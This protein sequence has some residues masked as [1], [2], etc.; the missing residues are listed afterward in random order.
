MKCSNCSEDI[1]EGARFCGN[2]GEPA[3]AV[4]DTAAAGP[5]TQASAAGVASEPES[6]GQE[7]F[8]TAVTSSKHKNISKI[9]MAFLI[10]LVTLLVSSIA[11]AAY[12]LF[13]VY[14]LPTNQEQEQP[15]VSESEETTTFELPTADSTTQFQ[16]P[17]SN[18]ASGSSSEY[19]VATGYYEFDI[20]EYWRGKVGWREET[21]GDIVVYPLQFPTL[22]L[23]TVR[24]EDASSPENAG[25]VATHESASFEDES[26]HR[27][28]IWTKNWVW[29]AAEG[30][31]SS[32]LYNGVPASEI[33][34]ADDVMCDLSTGGTVT[35][36]QAKALSPGSSNSAFL[37]D[38]QFIKTDVMSSF[39]ILP[40]HN[41][42]AVT[43]TN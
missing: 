4:V 28:E 43:I 7:N 37:A 40:S 23:M 27:V 42:P 1:N 9:S 29:I 18:S 34:T 16:T 5:Q 8:K 25:D 41:K 2:C 14:A 10:A 31:H 36:A 30:T 38:Q 6:T 13:T 26:N 32:S 20:P 11:F 22:S 35:V 39:T 17:S 21:N 24:L 15:V 33:S 19:H 3:P 12:Y